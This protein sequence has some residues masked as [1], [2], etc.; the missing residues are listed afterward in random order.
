MKTF[1]DRVIDEIIEKKTILSLGFDPQFDLVPP[2]VREEAR[3]KFY[4]KSLNLSDSQIIEEAKDKFGPGWKAIAHAYVDFSKRLIDGASPYTAAAAIKPQI[5][6]WEAYGA[7][8]FWAFQEIIEYARAKGLIII[9]DAK[10]EDGGPTA[11]YYARGY[12]GLV[13][14]WGNDDKHFTEVPS[15]DVDAMTIT[16]WIGDPMIEPFIE[17][18]KQRGKGVFVVDKTSFKPASRIQ[19]MKAESGQKNWVE[20]AKMVDQWGIGTEGTNEYGYRNIGVVMGA[21]FPEEAVLMRKILRD[22]F[23]LIPGFSLKGGLG[24][25]AKANESVAGINKDGLGGIVHMSRGYNYAYL[26]GPFKSEPEDFVKASAG[27]AERARDVLNE[28]LK[29]AGKLAW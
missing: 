10:R 26:E 21:T 11:E 25:G 28:A 18:V 15:V 14:Y 24:Q 2:P 1:V 5:A 8:G 22:R 9:L 27:T 20:L 23:F 17:T 7:W 3:K 13:P 29:R 19:E 16:L 4:P 12:L 6:F